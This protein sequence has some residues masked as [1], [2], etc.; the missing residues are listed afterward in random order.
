[1]NNSS[2]YNNIP[3]DL[4]KVIPAAFAWVFLSY[5]MIVLAIKVEWLRTVAWYILIILVCILAFIWLHAIRAEQIR[6]NHFHKQNGYQKTIYGPVLALNI[7]I[8]LLVLS[9]FIG[10]GINLWKKEN[11]QKRFEA[12]MDEIS[13]MKEKYSR[14]MGEEVPKKI[15]NVDYMDF[16][17]ANVSFDVNKRSYG[18]G[19]YYTWVRHAIITLQVTDAFD[20]IS[21]NLQY[22]HLCSLESLGNEA[23]MSAEKESLQAYLEL[24]EKYKD[25]IESRDGTIFQE[26]DSEYLIVTS[27]NK[28]EYARNVKDYFLLNGKDHFTTKHWDE[29]YKE[30][31][32]T[33]PA[34]K[35]T[36]APKKK[37]ASSNKKK[38]IDAYDEGYDDIYYNEDYDWD[39]YWRDQDYADGVDDAMEDEEW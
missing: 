16:V 31:P 20:G 19:S 3:D 8:I 23:L 2:P 34:P 30:H 36:P 32:K 25:Q 14:I 29:Y 17:E 4:K 6:I 22:D 33:S 13:E 24:Y 38:S 21:D 15:K 9:F 10:S 18:S 5:A 12:T 35:A 37:N 28:Y 1:M 11:D 26:Y 7:T 27:K 39:R